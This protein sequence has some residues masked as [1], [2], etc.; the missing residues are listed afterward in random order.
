MAV[1]DQVNTV[2][3]LDTAAL[4]VPQTAAMGFDTAPNVTIVVAAVA[5]AVAAADSQMEVM[6]N[7]KAPRQYSLA[8]VS[9]TVVLKHF[10]KHQ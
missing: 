7:F 8:M 9:G 4:V 1:A 10:P 3:E 5:V 2:V 6:D